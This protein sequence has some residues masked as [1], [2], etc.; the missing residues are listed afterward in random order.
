MK[1]ARIHVEDLGELLGE[2]H[3]KTLRC[4]GV[5]SGRVRILQG[6]TVLGSKNFQGA[7][8]AL[9]RNH[10]LMQNVR[11]EHHTRRQLTVGNIVAQHLVVQHRKI[12]GGI[13]RNN[14]HAVE[15]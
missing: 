5:I 8:A 10:V 6:D 15:V 4:L 2:F 11:V 13:E 12:V 14:R 3:Q 9:T 7:L 1:L